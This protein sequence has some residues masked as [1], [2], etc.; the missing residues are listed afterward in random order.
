[1]PPTFSI[2]TDLAG[3]KE[4]AA[5]LFPA[6][7]AAGFQAV[8]WCQDWTGQPV[9]YDEAIARNV[10]RLAGECGLRVA[11]VHAFSGTRPEGPPWT[12]ELFEAINRNRAEFAARVGAEVLV[13]H[14]PAMPTPEP[15]EAARRAVADVGRLLPACRELSVRLAIENLA[16]PAHTPALFDALFEAFA[17]DELGFCYDSGHALLTD[18]PGLIAR[19]ADRLAATHLHDN[20]GWADQHRPPGEGVADWPMI[21]GTIKRSRYA[22][23]VN[24]EVHLP[25]DED[26]A[27]FCKRIR[28]DLAE[29]WGAA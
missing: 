26:L 24:L 16:G 7:A 2:T 4:D 10:A 22:G 13:L 15:A 29:R 9:F 28:T 5:R 8:H 1:M 27:A 3:Q 14:L 11:D 18:E 19:Y 25:P 12:D 21:L 6:F 17:P 23:T 20:D